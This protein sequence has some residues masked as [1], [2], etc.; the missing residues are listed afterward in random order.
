LRHSPWWREHRDEPV[1][2]TGTE[3]SI[4]DHPSPGRSA[5][6]AAIAAPFAAFGP[7]ASRKAQFQG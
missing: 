4:H 7:E 6:A 5:F 1:A 3:W 2:D